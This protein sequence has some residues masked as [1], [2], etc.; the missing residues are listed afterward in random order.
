MPPLGSEQGAFP[1][2]PWTLIQRIQAPD[3]SH[4][5]A[6]LEQVC[7]LYW[8]PLYSWLRRRGETPEDS[9]DL[10]Q[11][12]FAYLLRR[13]DFV[14][15]EH[16]KGRL[17]TF[18]LKALK[19]FALKQVERESAKKRG[20]VNIDFRFDAKKGE[21]RFAAEPVDNAALTPDALFDRAWATDL[22]RRVFSKLRAEYSERGAEPV[23]DALKSHIP[24][25]ATDEPLA[26]VALALGMKEG[27]V[28]VAI[29]RLRKRFR[30]LLEKEVLETVSDPEDVD[31]EFC[32]LHRVFEGG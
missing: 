11:G 10:V 2:T 7:L 12:L 32:F 31:E 16:E 24:W 6:A 5:K 19:R 3:S 17:R 21:A 14:R 8:Y 20:G 4:A 9:E 25:N 30:R 23:F 18:L 26:D 27:A 15:L 22:L 13:D 29:F 28:R 1:Q